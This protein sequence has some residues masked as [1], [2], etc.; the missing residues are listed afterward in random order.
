MRIGIWGV[1][2]SL[3][4]LGS[5]SVIG[6]GLGAAPLL[7]SGAGALGGGLGS[8]FLRTGLLVD[9]DGIDRIGGPATPAALGFSNGPEVGLLV[10]P[11]G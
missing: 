9:P 2:F 6:A 5:G 7:P 10:D 1:V 11:D 4:A 8:V 3:L